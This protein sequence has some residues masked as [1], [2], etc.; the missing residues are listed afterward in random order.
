MVVFMDKAPPKPLKFKLSHSS[1]LFFMLVSLDGDIIDYS[2]NIHVVRD[3][4]IFML[5][6]YVFSASHPIEN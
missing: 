3:L 5:F 6:S 2:L 1:L 4:K